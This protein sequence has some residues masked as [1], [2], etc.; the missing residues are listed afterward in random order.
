MILTKNLAEELL[1]NKPADRKSPDFSQ[2]SKLTKEGFEFV[3]SNKIIID[4][5][6][7]TEIDT[8]I[9]DL[10]FTN[11][12]YYTV[13]FNGLKELTDDQ[14]DL[15]SKINASISLNGVTNISKSVAEKL[16]KRQ[17]STSD[18]ISLNGIE[19]I[20][21][22]TFDELSKI[23]TPVY[24]DGLKYFNVKKAKSLV[25]NHNDLFSMNG[26]ID[27]EISVI[28]ILVKFKGYLYLNGLVNL[29]ESKS[30]LFLRYQGKS[31]NIDK[32]NN[33]LYNKAVMIETYPDNSLSICVVKLKNIDGY[34]YLYAIGNSGGGTISEYFCKYQKSGAIFNIFQSSDI[35]DDA[36]NS[37]VENEVSVADKNLKMSIQ[38]KQS[39]SE[40]LNYTKNEWLNY[41]DDFSILPNSLKLLKK[42][43]FASKS[44]EE[45]G[46]R[47]LQIISKNWN[48]N[49]R[50][51]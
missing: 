10:L 42:N 27:I 38:D 22:E 30:S 28:D 3:L 9:F 4:F 26:L 13:S 37:Y 23:K 6:S 40:I 5:P 2:I 31:L 18:S 19:E 34:T 43:Y 49:Y 21:D 46:T 29:D 32:K 48:L 11:K 24:L 15:F 35:L 20:D 51:R 16:T 39:I 8:E 7:V 12:N 36:W 33:L 25:K 47:I 41:E 50:W 1:K 44:W 17:K 14:A 45:E